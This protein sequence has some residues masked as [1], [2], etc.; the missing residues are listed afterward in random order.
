MAL[1]LNEIQWAEPI[2]PAAPDPQW[3]AE[4]RRRGGRPFEVDR[5]IARAVGCVKRR[6]P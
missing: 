5:R 4:L 6:S 1:S 2:L 3:E